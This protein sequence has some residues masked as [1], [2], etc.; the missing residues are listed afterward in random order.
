MK[1]KINAISVYTLSVVVATLAFIL[2]GAEIITQYTMYVNGYI[3]IERHHLTDNLGFGLLLMFGLIPEII[4]GVLFGWFI[5][6]KL[7][8]KF[9]H[10]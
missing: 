7:N 10:T 9:N 4:F 6:K 5:G 1:I 3:E 2:I 8:V